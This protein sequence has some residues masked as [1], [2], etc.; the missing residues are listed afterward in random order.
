MRKSFVATVAIVVALAIATPAVAGPRDR[1]RE[2]PAISFVKKLIKKI[3]K[4]GTTA[5]P[6]VPIPDEEDDTNN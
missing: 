5:D 3:F 6:T 2:L 4:A 1:D